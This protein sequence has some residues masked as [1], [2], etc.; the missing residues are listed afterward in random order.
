MRC[1]PKPSLRADFLLQRRGRERRRGIAAA[2][3]ALDRGDAELAGRGGFDRRA[4]IGGLLLVGD[5]E[6][7]DLLA[8]ELDQPRRKSLLRLLDVGI[9]ASST[10]AP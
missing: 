10:R 5:G 8:A 7:L 6:L 3:L 1:A 9:D 4:H 2:L